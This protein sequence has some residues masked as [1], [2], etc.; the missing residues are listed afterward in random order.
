MTDLA[1]AL[2]EL[3]T[4]SG[5][6]FAGVQR[7]LCCLTFTDSERVGDLVEATGVPH[8]RV[9]EVLRRLGFETTDDT[10]RVGEAGRD[11]LRRLLHCDQEA[12]PDRLTEMVAEVAEGLPPAVWSL[13]HVPATEATIVDRAR[14]LAAQ[15]DLTGRHLV[16]LGDHDLTAVATRLLVPGAWSAS[17][18]STSGCWNISTR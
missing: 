7:L 15:Y 18:I 12:A 1:T 14:Y 16:C 11:E 6:T 5:V 10:I 17:S 3:R 2:S 13:D 8:R 9:V 4:E